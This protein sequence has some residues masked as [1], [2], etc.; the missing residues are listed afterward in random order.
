MKE[1]CK[2]WQNFD[3]SVTA[4]TGL[5]EIIDK[6]HLRD[7]DVAETGGGALD[8]PAEVAADDDD[9]DVTAQGCST[10]SMVTSPGSGCCLKI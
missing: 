5:K 10:F 2:A 8:G 6:S 9:D 7:D 1:I 4:L 3:R